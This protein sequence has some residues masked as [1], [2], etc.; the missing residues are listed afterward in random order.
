MKKYKVDLQKLL[1]GLNTLTGRDMVE[2]EFNERRAGNNSA[3]LTFTKSFQAR[4]AARALK[5]DY[6]VLQALPL[7]QYEQMCTVVFVFLQ[8]GPEKTA[9]LV[10]TQLEDSTEPLQLNSGSTEQ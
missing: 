10:A 9:N 5:E 6:N 1:T 3:D 7:Y 8:T 4:L 2:V